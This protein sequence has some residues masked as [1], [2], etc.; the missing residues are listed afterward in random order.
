VIVVDD[1]LLVSRLAD[2]AM[3]GL[4]ERRFL[5]LSEYGP[6]DPTE[7]TYFLLLQEGDSLPALERHMGF[8]VLGNRFNDRVFGDPGYRPCAE[9]I[10]DRDHFYDL[11]YNLGDAGAGVNLLVPKLPGI[12]P[13]LL[14]LCQHFAVPATGDI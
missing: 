13:Q 5:V 1:P 8:S 9:S 7:L 14:A 3:R 4:V 10:E 11:I 2:P 12:P 6:Y